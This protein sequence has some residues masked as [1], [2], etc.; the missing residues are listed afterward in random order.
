MSL[1]RHIKR[2]LRELEH[3]LVDG[4]LH[5]HKDVDVGDALLYY[6]NIKVAVYELKEKLQKGKDYGKPD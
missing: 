4:H 6:G 3:L 1:E 5:N 2:I